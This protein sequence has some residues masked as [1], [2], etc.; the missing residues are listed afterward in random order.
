MGK[1]C[2]LDVIGPEAKSAP[3]RH[4]GLGS[5]DHRLPCSVFHTCLWCMLNEDEMI[6]K[7]RMQMKINI[8]MKMKIKMK[9]GNKNLMMMMMKMQMQ[10][11]MC[12]VVG[13]FLAGRMD[14]PR[15]KHCQ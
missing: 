9:M 13:A 7:T 10:M 15:A 5:T 4:R 14:M 6:M 2:H 3:R 8:K 1:I 11:Q 12:I